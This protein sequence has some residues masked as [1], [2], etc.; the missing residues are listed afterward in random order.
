MSQTTDT[1]AKVK[2]SSLKVDANGTLI[3]GNTGKEV[4]GLFSNQGT[5]FLQYYVVENNYTQFIMPV[6]KTQDTI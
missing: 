4:I 5:D 1:K 2:L 6:V 3:E